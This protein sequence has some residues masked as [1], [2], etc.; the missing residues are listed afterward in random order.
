MLLDFSLDE[1]KCD[2]CAKSKHRMKSRPKKSLTVTSGPGHIVVS[3]ASG[4]FSHGLGYYILV[5]DVHTKFTM[6]TWL[7]SLSAE[8][9]LTIVERFFELVHNLYYRYPQVF[10]CDRGTNYTAKLFVEGI[11]DFGTQVQHADTEAHWQNGH[12]EKRVDVLQTVMQTWRQQA[13]T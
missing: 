13:W 12:A 3:D 9:T 4:P 1:F 7:N 2:A 5:V 8:K 6:V 10:R 11:M